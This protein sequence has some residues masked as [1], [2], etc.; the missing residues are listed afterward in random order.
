MNLKKIKT[1]LWVSKS[2]VGLMVP[3]RQAGPAHTLKGVLGEWHHCPIP[4]KPPSDPGGLARNPAIPAA[5]DP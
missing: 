5:S 1:F 4:W 3:S 2:I